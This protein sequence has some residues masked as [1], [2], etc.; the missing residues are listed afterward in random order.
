MMNLDDV[1][2]RAIVE[3]LGLTPQTVESLS[4]H[5]RAARPPLVRARLL[6]PDD[7]GALTSVVRRYTLEPKDKS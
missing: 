6:L 1:E 2:G 3:A 7:T 4:I 5:L